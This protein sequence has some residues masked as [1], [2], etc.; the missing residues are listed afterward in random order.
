M[1]FGGHLVWTTTSPKCLSCTD[2]ICSWRFCLL[3]AG[4][5]LPS[6]VCILCSRLSQWS[7]DI[8]IWCWW[9]HGHGKRFYCHLISSICCPGFEFSHLSPQSLHME[10][11]CHIIEEQRWTKLDVHKTCMFISKHSIWSHRWRKVVV[12]YMLASVLAHSH[13]WV[14][15][16][17]GVIS[18]HLDVLRVQYMNTS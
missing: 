7:L 15:S 10:F 18:F 11:Q 5:G 2:W 13:W 8:E 12:L 1:V 6:D 9:I 17:L 3:V 16:V 14:H 4:T